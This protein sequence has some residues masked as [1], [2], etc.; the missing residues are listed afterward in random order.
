VVLDTRSEDIETTSK[1]HPLMAPREKIVVR[2]ARGTAKTKRMSK[3]KMKLAAQKHQKPSDIA[4]QSPSTPQYRRMFPL[5]KAMLL[6]KASARNASKSSS[7]T[8]TTTN[9]K[10]HA[11]HQ[12]RLKYYRKWTKQHKSKKEPEFT[13]FSRLP[14]E[15]RSMIF[16][17][18]CPPTRRML[19]VTIQS[20]NPRRLY[21][22][23]LHF[24]LGLENYNT[25]CRTTVA[26]FV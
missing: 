17:F 26:S 9:A 1:H 22:A 19:P 5:K 11:A 20:T 24:P 2:K 23:A 15:L 14:P 25:P 13:P 16:G 4:A 8:N 10:T 21:H 12:L 7:K 18:I 3:T 6:I